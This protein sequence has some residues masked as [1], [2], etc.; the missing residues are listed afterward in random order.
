MS[1]PTPYLVFKSAALAGGAVLL[2]IVCVEAQMAHRLKGSIRDAAGTALVGATVRA[3]AI[4]GFRG[5]PFAGAKEETAVSTPTGEWSMTGLEAG[6]WMFSTSAEEM[7]P[8]V[9]V[10][11]VKLSQRQQ[12]SAVGNSLTWQ[13]LLSAA[14]RSQHHVLTV[15]VELIAS[16]KTEE[17]LQALTVALGPD[18][19]DETR[20]MAGEMALV[21][22][23][24]ALANALFAMVLRTRPTH[25]RATLG[26]ASAALMSLDWEK[27][28]KLLWDAR[29]LAPQEQ[30]PALAAAID[31]V[32]RLT[33]GQ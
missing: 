8:A 31:E 33:S 17:A 16:R 13:L 9:V 5:Q 24:P 23:N 12:I 32:R 15:A 11:P 20:V 29:A 2:T 28:G 27:A 18:V 3:E 1:N 14:P 7:L 21:A 25:S 19:N 26:A 22:R 6:L 30:R 10:L 4:T